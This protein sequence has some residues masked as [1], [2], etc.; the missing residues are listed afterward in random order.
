MQFLLWI[1]V[2]LAAGWLTGKKMNGYGYGPLMDMLI[3]SVGGLMGGFSMSV[4]GFSGFDD[5][6]YA[7]LVAVLSAAGFTA[8]VARAS[9]KQRYA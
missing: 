1:I 2:G 9:G 3:G 7:T 8:F 6:T 5:M 4:A